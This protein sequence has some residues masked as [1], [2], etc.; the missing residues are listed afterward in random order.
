MKRY[1]NS[2]LD[3]RE[4]CMGLLNISQERPSFALS[5]ELLRACCTYLQDLHFAF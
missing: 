5:S 2:Y 4:Q 3:D 1:D